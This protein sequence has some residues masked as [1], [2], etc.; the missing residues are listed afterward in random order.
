MEIEYLVVYILESSTK[1]RLFSRESLAEAFMVLL[2][3]TAD[4]K[5]IPLRKDF[6]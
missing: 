2:P 1:Y 3:D 5:I 4:P 6:E